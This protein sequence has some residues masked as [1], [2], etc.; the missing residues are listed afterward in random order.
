MNLGICYLYEEKED[1]AIECFKKA[2]QAEPRY[3]YAHFNLGSTYFDQARYDLAVSHLEKAIQYDPHF[4]AAYEICAM[5]Y[6]ILKQKQKAQGL[7]K[8][9]EKIKRQARLKHVAR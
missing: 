5:A 9:A 2:V 3:A 4:L 1:A 7:F 6:L 8:K